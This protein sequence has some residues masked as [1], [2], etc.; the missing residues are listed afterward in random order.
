MNCQLNPS[1][2]YE[3]LHS[4]EEKLVVQPISPD[5]RK[6]LAHELEEV[7]HVIEAL[8][9]QA[10][11]INR[12]AASYFKELKETIIKLYG[13]LDD[14]TLKY[15]VAIIEQDAL[16]LETF[17]QK[18]DLKKLARAVNTL[19]YHIKSLFE[20]YAPS[21]E[22][23]RVVAF[24][25]LQLQKATALLEGKSYFDPFNDLEGWSYLETEGVLETIAELL[26]QNERKAAKLL[27][28]R[29]SPA[30]KL[31]FNAYFAPDDLLPRLLHDVESST[32]HH[33]LIAG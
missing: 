13:K 10:N 12:F 15:R 20:S 21:F 25:Q 26:S 22:E 18:G 17:F 29:L 4:I 23:R 2:C 19:Q 33:Q 27:F 16:K 31:L 24:A 6:N 3:R 32:H 30:Q 9:A 8:E 11:Y 1:Q 14:S 5:E 7:S 28:K